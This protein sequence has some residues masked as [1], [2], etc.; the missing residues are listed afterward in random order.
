MKKMMK[1]IQWLVWCLFFTGES[2]GAST[3][4]GRSWGMISAIVLIYMTLLAALVM[5]DKEKKE[6]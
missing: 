2:Y 1:K 6:N 3:S 4:D 5:M